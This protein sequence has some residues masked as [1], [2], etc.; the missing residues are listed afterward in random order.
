MFHIDIVYPLNAVG[1]SVVQVFDGLPNLKILEE[2]Y[3]I[4]QPFS[5]VGI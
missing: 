3:S 1:L 2:N 4:P 5:K